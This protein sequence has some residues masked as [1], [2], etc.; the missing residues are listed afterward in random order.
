MKPVPGAANSEADA[1]VADVA[2]ASV[3]YYSRIATP[4]SK[5]ISENVA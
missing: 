4:T 1:A 5:T 2:A 3:C